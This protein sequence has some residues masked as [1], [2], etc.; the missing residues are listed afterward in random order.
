MIQVDKI[1]ID[2]KI[3]ENNKKF[4]ELEP[5]GY[6]YKT[7]RNL[8][9]SKWD[10]DWEITE[11]ISILLH[12]WNGAFYRYGFFKIDKLKEWITKNKEVLNEL[13]NKKITIDNV[14]EVNYAIL[15][16]KIFDELIEVTKITN[17]KKNAKSK[18]LRTPV[19]VAKT[20]HLL[21][22]ELFPLWDD[23]IAKGMG[24]IWN[25]GKHNYSEKYLECCI[26]TLNFKNKIKEKRVIRELVKNDK[27]I[28][29]II[30]EFNYILFTKEEKHD[31]KRLIYPRLTEEEIEYI[32][33]IK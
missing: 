11:A 12:I 10:N 9:E 33:S 14:M 20:L 5:R 24:V 23:A 4:E 19:G 13:K 8:I 22:P 3:V 21:V 18:Y 2:K 31:T 6:I 17:P 15:I 32:V 30:D 26:K 27:G 16:K 7:S 28:L 25:S 29:K 1:N